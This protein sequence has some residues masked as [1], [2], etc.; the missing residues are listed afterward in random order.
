MEEPF[1]RV[2]RFDIVDACFKSEDILDEVLVIN[3][4][5]LEGSCD[6]FM[7]KESPSVGFDNVVLPNPF[8][9]SHVSPVYLQSFP[10]PEY[11]IDVP[12]DNSMICDAD[13]G[14]EDNMFS[15]LDGNIDNCNNSTLNH[16]HLFN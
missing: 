16:I 1:G 9:H 3:E 10:P 5:P 15:M 7:H 13:L 2:A 4:T 6:V 12:M 8:D 14:Y 11:Y